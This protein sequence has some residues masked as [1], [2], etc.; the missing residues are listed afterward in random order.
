[1]AKK[2]KNNDDVIEVVTDVDVT[3]SYIHILGYDTVMDDV[4]LKLETKRLPSLHSVKELENTVLRLSKEV[5]R[6]SAESVAIKKTF[7]KKLDDI[8]SSV[9]N[10]KFKSN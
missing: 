3:P 5:Q 2:K 6:L 9:E 4:S 10:T 1:M 8:K 7:A